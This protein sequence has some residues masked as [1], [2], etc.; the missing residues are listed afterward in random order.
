MEYQ[1]RLKKR[2]LMDLIAYIKTSM[3]Q[4]KL[5]DDNDTNLGMQ[6]AQD[7]QE[8]CLFHGLMHEQET[9]GEKEAPELANHDLPAVTSNNSHMGLPLLKSYNPCSARARHGFDYGKIWS[10]KLLKQ[11]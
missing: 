5:D 2:H 8:H 11:V 10:E 6:N 9:A 7:Y 3:C 4:I 1:A